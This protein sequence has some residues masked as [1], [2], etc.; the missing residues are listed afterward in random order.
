LTAAAFPSTRWILRPPDPERA[1]ALAH[2]LDVT[3]PTAQVLVHRGLTEPGTAERFLRAGLDDLSDPDR[4]L[5]MTS[6]A[7]RVLAA[8]RRRERIIVYGD[9]DA[10]GVTATAVLLRGLGRLG[11]PAEFFIPR[12]Q[13]E[14]YGLNADAIARF[15][16]P[17]VLLAADC[18][19]TA[20]DEVAFAVSRGLD[21]IVLDHHEPGERLPAAY[22][23]VAPKRADQPPVTPYAACGL[24]YQLVRA[25]WRMAGEPEEPAALLDLVAIGTLADVVPLVGDNR[26]FARQGLERLGTAPALGVAALLREADVTGRVT[27]RDVTFGLAPRLNAAGRLGD[28]RIAV[29][30]LLTGDA[31]EAS[32]LA[33]RL[34]EENRRRQEITDRVLTEAAARVEESGWQHEPA[35]V[36]SGEGWHPGVIGIVASHLKERYCRPVVMIAVEDGVGKGS[37]RSIDALPMVDALDACADLLFRYGGHAMAAGLTI[38]PEQIPAF[39]ARFLQEAGRRLR[40]EDLLPALTI[41]AEL[42]L[43]DLTLALARELELVAPYGSG[44]PEPVFAVRGLRAAATRVVGEGHLRLGLTDGRGFVEAIGFSRGDVAEVL[45]FTGARLDVA[46]VPELDRWGDQEKVTLIL[47]DLVTPGLDLDAVLADGKLLLE[48]LFDRADDYLA[49][50]WRGI[51]QAWSFYTKVAGVTFEGRQD[52]IPEVRAGQPLRLVREPANPHDPH[53]VAVVTEDGRQLGYLSARLAG[54]LAPSIDAGTRYAVM[55]SQVTG[56]G[57]RSYGLNIFIQRE[58][59]VAPPDRLLWMGWRD[60]SIEQL[61]DRLRLYLHPGQP[62]REVQ[63]HIARAALEGGRAATALGPGRRG[64]ATAVLVAAGLAI[65]RARPAVIVLPLAGQVDQW[66]ETF[67]P[68]LRETGLRVYRAHGALPLRPQQR[69][70]RALEE[71]RVDLLLASVEWLRRGGL[72]SVPGAGVLVADP[73]AGDA[74]LPSW[75]SPSGSAAHR[76]GAAVARFLWDA[77]R[78]AT[79]AADL[80][81]DGYVRA[82]LRLIDRRDVD[83]EAQIGTWLAGGG[84]TMVFVPDRADAVATAR[85]LREQMGSSVAYYHGGLP[86]RVR[87]VLEQLFADG[88]ITVLVSTASFPEVFAPGDITQVILSGLP[89]SRTQFREIAALAGLAGRAATVILAYTQ[90]DADRARARLDER[91]PARARLADLYRLLRESG[92]VPLVWPDERLGRV[93]EGAGWSPAAV[94]AGLD[95]LAEAGVLQREVSEGRWRIELAPGERRDLTISGRFAEGTRE[96][97]ALERLLPWAFG[98]AAAILRVLAGPVARE[99]RA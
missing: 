17:G 94:Q 53:A 83:R 92:T 76:A 51:E 35:V 62:L 63:T 47:R 85:R 9:Y 79:E 88:K 86:L 89:A 32:A 97:A 6:A 64:A 78:A 59:P 99:F 56:G 48:R 80:I 24:A 54:R 65:R 55:A 19:I 67:G 25:V 40:P 11:A 50:E 57:E 46:G 71:G 84:K 34:D 44:N 21:V 3:F 77:D 68:L 10:D 52:L 23:V 5:D 31:G 29:A 66:N 8:L 4:L 61:L 60:L 2:A 1:T 91:Y 22:G 70:L 16:P 28:A 75:T 12:R 95:T 14:G 45:A 96:R 90:G 13:V 58:D 38:A 74:D 98:P 30:L 87:R 49:H 42:S 20:V 15:A 41:E 72:H 27:A 69:L 73:D 93:L 37:A 26:I 81:D 18:G 43:A 7:A 39:R 82:N 33:R 36:V